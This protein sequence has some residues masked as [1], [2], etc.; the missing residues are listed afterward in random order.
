MIHAYDELYLGCARKVLA[1]MLDKAV[2][3]YGMRLEDYYALFL[4]SSIAVRFQRGR[5]GFHISVSF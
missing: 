3:Q 4:V 5:N 1:Q 2:F